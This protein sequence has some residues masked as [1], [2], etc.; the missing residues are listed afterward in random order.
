[1]KANMVDHAR[2]ERR[3]YILNLGVIITV[4]ALYYIFFVLY[5]GGALTE[6]ETAY[7]LCSLNTVLCLLVIACILIYAVKYAGNPIA[8]LKYKHIISK[9][10]VVLIVYCATRIVRGFRHLRFA[11]CWMCLE[12]ATSSESKPRIPPRILAKHSS[13]SASTPPLY[14]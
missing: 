5:A 10:R 3:Q 9:T 13:L 11:A 2:I 1:M 4:I 7:L 14:L 6:E 12:S 8:D